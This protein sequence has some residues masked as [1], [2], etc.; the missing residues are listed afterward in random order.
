MFS[1]LRSNESI[2]IKTTYIRSTYN[3]TTIDNFRFADLEIKIKAE[4]YAGNKRYHLTD[5][6]HREHQSDQI[7]SCEPVDETT[8]DLVFSVT[9][10]E[11]HWNLCN[12]TLLNESVQIGHSNS[13]HPFMTLTPSMN[14]QLDHNK[15]IFALS[16]LSNSRIKLDPNNE[17]HADYS[18]E[19]E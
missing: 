2:N 19:S 8:I 6:K 18:L 14:F 1:N 4:I 3:L 16:P 10:D 9:R 11:F 17:F 12:Y 15:L 7:E 13:N 5:S